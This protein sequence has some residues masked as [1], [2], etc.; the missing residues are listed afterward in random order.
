MEKIKLFFTSFFVV[1]LFVVLLLIIFNSWSNCLTKECLIASRSVLRK[2]K[3]S[4]DP[5]VDFA[6]FA[7]GSNIQTDLKTT[8]SNRIMRK[9]VY[10]LLK[11]IDSKEPQFIENL[12]HLYVSCNNEKFDQY[13][14]LTMVRKHMSLALNRLYIDYYFDKRLKLEVVDM[15]NYIKRAFKELINK[16]NWLNRAT[17]K[18]VQENTDLIKQVIGYEDFLLNN[19]LLN[20]IYKEFN[21]NS[22]NYSNN[23]LTLNKLKEKSNL[24][25]L[26]KIQILDTNAHYFHK[27]HEIGKFPVSNNFFIAFNFLSFFFIVLSFG[28]LQKGLFGIN[29]PKYLNYGA[30]GTIIGHEMIHGIL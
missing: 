25:R 3:L 15:I 17:K 30:L 11:P 2:M 9:L 8:L 23:L 21:F 22:K 6:K 28:V 14:C 16:S 19:T 13:Y 24:N 4:V 18:S 7:C 26:S 20:D 5:C 29:Y 27:Y 10:A 12:K 1:F